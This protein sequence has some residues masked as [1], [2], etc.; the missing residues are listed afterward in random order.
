MDSKLVDAQAAHETT[1]SATL[2]ALAGANIIY[3]LG[4]LEMGMTFDY[5]KLVMDNEFAYMIKHAVR[6]IP[7][8]AETLAVD[9]IK[10]VGAGGEFVS[11]E[12]TYRHFKTEQSRSKLIDRRM[13][14]EWAAQGGQSLLEKANEVAVD[15]Y[16]NY[17]APAL[18]TDVQAKLREIVNAAEDH[19]GVALS[20]E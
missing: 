10:Q 6:G 2:A 4:M 5:A 7:V 13:P 18:G 19:Y 20:C 15:L 16:L 8:N 14:E 17:K 3:G 9:V 1:L 11:H 12:H